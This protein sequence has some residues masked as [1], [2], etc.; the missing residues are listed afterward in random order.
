V[1]VKLF[2]RTKNVSKQVLN[3][4]ICFDSLDS[5]ENAAHAIIALNGVD[6]GGRPARVKSCS[7]SL[8]FD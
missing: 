6:I 2:I 8:V 5:H 1:E 3:K 4:I 7:H